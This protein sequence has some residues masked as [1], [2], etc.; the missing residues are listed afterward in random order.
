[1][2]EKFPIGRSAPDPRVVEIICGGVV[3][4]IASPIQEKN[5]TDFIPRVV[6]VPPTNRFP[7]VSFARV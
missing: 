4:G 5:G 1:M 6:N 2:T 3:S 7:S